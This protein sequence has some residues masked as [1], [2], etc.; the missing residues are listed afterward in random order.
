MSR[1]ADM[2]ACEITMTAE[3]APVIDFSYP[4]YLETMTFVT[5]SPNE[6]SRAFVVLKPFNKL[7]RS[8]V[9]EFFLRLNKESSNL[10]L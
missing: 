4:Y 1:R 8:D 6:V 5:T 9:N 3:R 10:M 2:A 7:V